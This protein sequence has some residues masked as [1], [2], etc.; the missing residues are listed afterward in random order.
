MTTQV[1]FLN[2]LA[3]GVS[4]ADYERWVREVDYPKARSLKSIESYTVVR[5]EGHLREATGALPADY[6]EA[7]V[8]TDL[9][10]YRAEL[11]TPSAGREEFLAQLRSY[12]GDT[13]AVYG[14]LIE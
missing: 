11:E 7:V 1:F 14:T 3:P 12:I 13:Q 2:R 9:E 10:E 4:S 5:L 8:V 6:L